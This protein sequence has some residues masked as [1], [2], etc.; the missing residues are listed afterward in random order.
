MHARLSTWR[1]RPEDLE[2]LSREVAPIVAEVKRQPGYIAG[3]DLTTA[4]DTHMFVTIW[5]G[6]DQM[7]AAFDQASAAMR[8]IV[9]SGRLELLN[10]TS[11]PAEE[12][13]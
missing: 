2:A 13:A 1:V 7:R 4:P 10:V 5:E 11:C 9:E 12:W 3:Y 8:P 6:E